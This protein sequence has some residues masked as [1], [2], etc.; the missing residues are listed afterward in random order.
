[1]S[2]CTTFY[3]SFSVDKVWACFQ[4][5]DLAAH[6]ASV[7]DPETNA[8]LGFIT[9]EDVIEELLQEEISDEKDAVGFLLWGI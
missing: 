6:M 1:M 8:L 5:A 3:P 7:Y 2:H 9:L 4:F